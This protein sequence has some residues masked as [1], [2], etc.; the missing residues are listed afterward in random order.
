[1]KAGDGGHDFL[2]GA[3][4]TTSPAWRERLGGVAAAFALD[5]ESRFSW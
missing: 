2:G 5:N 1:M 3:G 4:A